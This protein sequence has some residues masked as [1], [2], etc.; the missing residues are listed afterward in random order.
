M[1]TLNILT[2]VSA[3]DKGYVVGLGIMSGSV[4]VKYQQ[5]RFVLHVHLFL[6]KGKE[7]FNSGGRSQ[8]A[9][10]LNSKDCGPLDLVCKS[11]QNLRIKVYLLTSYVFQP[12]STLK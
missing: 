7:L 5:Q 11:I 6:L 9:R 12:A 4:R 8:L 10:D 3:E 1:C 2:L